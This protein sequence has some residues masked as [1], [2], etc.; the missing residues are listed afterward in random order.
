M[1]FYLLFALI[2]I[3]TIFTFWF[4]MSA[5]WEK[6]PKA[7]TRGVICTVAMLSF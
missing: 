6:E 3:Y 4:A 1:I 2:C 5:Y 7:G